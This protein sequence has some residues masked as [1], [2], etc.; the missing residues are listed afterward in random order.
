VNIY[1]ESDHLS[2]ASVSTFHIASECGAVISRENFARYVNPADAPACQRN[3]RFEDKTVRERIRQADLVLLVAK[4]SPWQAHYLNETVAALKALGAKRVIVVG[5]K[6]FGDIS[7][8]RYVGL[9]AS[10]K[11]QLRN[12]VDSQQ[13]AANAEMRRTLTSDEF[14]DS[15]KLLCGVDDSCPVF[16]ED[17]H[18]IS[19]DGNHLTPAGALWAGQRL[20]QDK[21]LASLGS[22]R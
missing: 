6:S 17:A 1:S 19:Y 12:A 3:G 9:S 18:L 13:R 2:G 7:P 20:F 4:W 5:R 15:Q 16:T 21:L 11:A 10:R 8:L 14:I 22:K